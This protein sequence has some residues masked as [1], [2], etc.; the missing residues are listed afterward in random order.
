MTYLLGQPMTKKVKLKT[1]YYIDSGVYFCAVLVIQKRKGQ[2]DSSLLDCDNNIKLK[3]QNLL[4][5]NWSLVA[6]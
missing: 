6:G 2:A 5:I 4:S 3:C 1:K